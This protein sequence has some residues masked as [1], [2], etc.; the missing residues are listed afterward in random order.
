MAVPPERDRAGAG[1]PGQAPRSAAVCG[2]EARAGAEVDGVATVVETNG[3]SMRLA[4]STNAC[5]G[6][7]ISID[8]ARLLGTDCGGGGS[9]VGGIRW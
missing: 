4:A 9:T 8:P 1:G 6:V 5:N 2:V 3:G 7:G